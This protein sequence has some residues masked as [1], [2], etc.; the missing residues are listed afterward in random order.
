MEL[1]HPSSRLTE[2]PRTQSKRLRRWLSPWVLLVLLV[3]GVAM[4]VGS[5][6]GV[7][8]LGPAPRLVEW[9]SNTR[10]L[11]GYA[12]S[13]RSIGFGATRCIVRR[14]ESSAGTTRGEEPAPWAVLPGELQLVTPKVNAGS[15]VGGMTTVDEVRTYAF[16][17]PLRSMRWWSEFPP[18][19]PPGL[20]QGLIWTPTQP[21]NRHGG[22]EIEPGTRTADAKMLPLDVCVWPFAVN[23]VFWIWVT[24]L[25]GE[26]G[27]RMLRRVRGRR[28]R[29]ARVCPHCGY[30]RAG[31]G[32]EV[33]CPECGKGVGGGGEDGH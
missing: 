8:L 12:V 25:G 33:V 20:T 10:S 31:L 13:T 16:G 21:I 9:S 30:D 22:S 2:R 19:L 11:G 28:E 24:V 6:W 4:T 15:W 3:I 14:G 18:A 32:A 26:I 29:L 17:W 23:V 27:L 1:G 5:A 7:A